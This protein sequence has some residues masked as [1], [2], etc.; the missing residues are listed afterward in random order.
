M[1]A[2]KQQ[3]RSDI[4]A[5]ILE[6]ATR[7]FAIHGF[8][9]ASLD[10]IANAAGIRK[11]SLLYHFV[12]KEDLRRCVLERLLGHWSEVI[13]SILRA[14]NSGAEQFE[15]IAGLTLA[16]FEEDPNRAR[17]LLRELL[18]RP[19]EMAPLIELQV[20]PWAGIMSDYIRSEERRVGKECRSRWA[21]YH[22]KQK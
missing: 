20:R 4:P 9:G 15:A 8:A 11:P 14:A 18:D 3:P 5:R 21:Q 16:F 13:P 22:I 1:P 19:Q 17:L 7:L 2:D 12:S 10:D 6:E